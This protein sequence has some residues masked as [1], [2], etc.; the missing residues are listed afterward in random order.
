M[1]VVKD[2][3]IVALTETDG[4]GLTTSVVFLTAKYSEMC[5][6]SGINNE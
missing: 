3:R 5:L 6:S 2:F 1:D 4:D